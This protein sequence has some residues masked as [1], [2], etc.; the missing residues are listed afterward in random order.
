MGTLTRSDGVN[1]SKLAMMAQYTQNVSL[2]TTEEY[3]ALLDE[4]GVKALLSENSSL[5]QTVLKTSDPELWY[6]YIKTRRETVAEEDAALFGM[7][8]ASLGTASSFAEAVHAPTP[9]A[10]AC[11]RSVREIEAARRRAAHF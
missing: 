8:T 1:L 6:E 2:K 10:P 7:Q 5:V 3:A 4:Q 9:R 11:F